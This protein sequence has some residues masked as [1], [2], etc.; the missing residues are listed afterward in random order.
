MHFLDQAKVF[1]KSGDGGGG[2]VS[3]R[4]EKY[5][6]RG[7]PDG[8]DG[9]DGGNVYVECVAGLNTLIDFRYK[10]HFKG[11]RGQNGKGSNRMGA[12]G[13][14]SVL[15]APLGT[16]VFSSE[17]GEMIAD[18][19]TVGQRVVLARGG[20]GGQGNARFKTSVNQAPR[21][22][23]PGIPGEEFWVWLRLKLLAD[24]G[25]VGKPNAGKSTFLSVCSRAK[26]KISDYPFTTLTPQLGVVD[27]DHYR[28]VIA[29]IPGL[30]EDAHLG[31]GVGIRFLGHIERCRVLF[32]LIDCFE[33]N[34]DEI[35]SS[36][37]RELEL[38]RQDF[39]ESAQFT[40]DTSASPLTERKEVICL[41]KV[42]LL[43]EATVKEKQLKIAEIAGCSPEDIM[44]VSGVTGAGVQDV[45]RRLAFLT[46]EEKRLEI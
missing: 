35:Y 22:S 10:Q 21:I 46:Q 2:C 33:E 27:I 4:R 19:L 13:E 1:I 16:Q 30:I 17:T 26:P 6:P 14:D 44:L 41:N 18:M 39:G 40:N 43:D 20:K 24:V 29:D 25:L 42:D 9:G 32:H 34:V 11:A 12:T 37:R 23:Q 45:L 15:Y 3:F 38:Y 5:V 36:V 7:G 28:F 8:G 31:A